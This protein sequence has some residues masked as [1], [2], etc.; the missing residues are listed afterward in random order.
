MLEHLIRDGY[1]PTNPLHKNPEIP[2]DW[3]E[4]CTKYND[5]FMY[6]Y[7]GY[8]A[9]GCHRDKDGW[10]ACV[11]DDEGGMD[12]GEIDRAILAFKAGKRNFEFD[13]KSMKG[14]FIINEDFAKRAWIAEANYPYN[15]DG[16]SWWEDG[17]AIN[18]DRA[19][20]LALF[21]EVVFG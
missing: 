9:Y 11:S 6:S 14:F 20:Q 4:F 15:S 13:K 1:P 16:Y 7:S 18:I 10:L 3:V 8:W 2:D 12:Q 19:I 21:D 5:I 17:D